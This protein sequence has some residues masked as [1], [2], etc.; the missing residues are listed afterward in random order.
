MDRLNAATMLP[1]L[2]SRFIELA[3]V[4]QRDAH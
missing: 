4:P 1:C 2:N 3:G